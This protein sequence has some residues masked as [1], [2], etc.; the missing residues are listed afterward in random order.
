MDDGETAQASVGAI[1]SLMIVLPAMGMFYSFLR[2]GKRIGLGF[3]EMTS[4]R[5]ILRTALGAVGVAALAGAAFVLIPNG[6]YRP[7]Q[8]DEEWTVSESIDSVSAFT[9]GRPSLTEEREEELGGAPTL[10]ESGEGFVP[11]HEADQGDEP[12]SVE[13]SD[14]QPDSED[15]EPAP[16]PTPTG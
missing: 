1:E 16:T 4:E 3:I 9:S 2:I 8:P 12:S 6:E 14:T 15:S 5:P 10:E 7:I 11:S 13:D